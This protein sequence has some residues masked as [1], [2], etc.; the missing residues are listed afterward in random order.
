M[1]DFPGGFF[2]PFWFRLFVS[3]HGRKRLLPITAALRTVLERNYRHLPDE[4][5][6]I[7]PDGVDLERYASLPDPVTARRELGLPV[8]S[9]VL[10]TGH[11]YEGRGADLFLALAGK[12]PQVSF[13][14]VGGR[15]TYVETWKSRAAAQSLANVTFTG[16]VSNA[17]PT[18][19]GYLQWR[20]HCRGLQ[21]DENVRVH[22]CRTCHP[23]Q[24]SARPSRSVG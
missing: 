22:G 2:G 12:Y 13:V 16:F 4:Q 7:A 19:G 10:C 6:V 8:A 11:L 1:H 21:P 3:W 5:V 9:T 18:D 23:D 17:L 15:P 20:E 14:W 24:R